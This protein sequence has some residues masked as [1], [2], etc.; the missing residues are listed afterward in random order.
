MF[1]FLKTLGR[2]GRESQLPELLAWSGQMPLLARLDPGERR[3]LAEMA[4]VFLGRKRLDGALGLTLDPRMRC[5]TALQAC[6]PVLNLGLDL[7]Q[8]WRSLI[9]YP[10]EFRAPYEFVDE[11]GVVHQGKRDLAGESWERGP[12][13]LAWEYVEQDAF[14]PEPAGNVTIHE[15]AH[16]LDLLNGDANGMPPLHRHM[17]PVLWSQAFGDAYQ[18]LKRQLRRGREPLL[19]PYA[20]ESPGELFAVASEVFFA[21]PENLAQ[22]YPQVYAQLRDYYRQDPLGGRTGA[23]RGDEAGLG[24]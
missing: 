15:M 13:I 14:D 9:L 16:K 23:G 1:S 22:A 19:D 5:L 3:R 6:L 20:A 24:G 18:D 10:D 7:Y 8:D 21:W 17:D 4:A 11:A 2:R 12:V